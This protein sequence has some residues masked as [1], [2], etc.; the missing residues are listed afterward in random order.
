MRVV[1]AREG[2]RSASSVAAARIAELLSAA[3]DQRG[4]ATFA[5]SGGATPE[6]MFGSLANLAVPWPRVD[7]FQVD[8][9]VVEYGDPAR[10]WSMTERALI[11]PTGAHGHPMTI[12]AQGSAETQ[13]LLRASDE[14][15]LKRHVGDPPAFDV[16][17]LGL[18]ADGHTASWAP[19]R[20]PELSDSLIEHVENFNGHER[21]TLA[22]RV[23]NSARAVIWLVLGEPKRQM[24]ER[25]LTGDPSI[26]AGAVNTDRSE[27]FTD[28]VVRGC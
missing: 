23:I 27:V 11:R 12:S 24:V 28:L 22:P 4:R 16:V 6:P 2:A 18:G 19:G 26:P 20:V 1:R 7:I 13:A 14:A 25:L 9:R 21:L 3:I 8:E 5:V 10:N 17:H 15:T